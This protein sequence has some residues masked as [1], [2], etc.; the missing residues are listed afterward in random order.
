[1]S[2]Y[3]LEDLNSIT[4]ILEEI[5]HRVD[6]MNNDLGF[7]SKRNALLELEVQAINQKLTGYSE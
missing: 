6:D 2:Q 1:M 4:S 5:L 7:L 3:I